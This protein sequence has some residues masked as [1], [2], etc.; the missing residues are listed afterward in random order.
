MP[1]LILEV[2]DNIIHE[3]DYKKLFNQLHHLLSERLPTQLSSCKSRMTSYQNY[4]I[5][6]GDK[7]NAFIH[8]TIKILPGRDEETLSQ[9]G[10]EVFQVLLDYINTHLLGYN[11]KM[12][13]ELLNLSRFYYKN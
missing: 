13:F 7:T 12:S 2:S 10:Q 8:L 6:E 3:I 4:Y 9:L 1:H 5:A 11:P